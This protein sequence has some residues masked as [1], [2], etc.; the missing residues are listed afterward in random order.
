ML[1]GSVETLIGKYD[2]DDDGV[3]DDDRDICFDSSIHRSS[4]VF[5]Y[6]VKKMIVSMNLTSSHCQL[7]QYLIDG[8]S[9][10][11][12]IAP[13]IIIHVYLFENEQLS[14]IG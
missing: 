4:S 5:K 14:E 1:F 12:V 7:Y 9:A 2:D 6:H 11:T 13:Y 3:D 10:E 8:L